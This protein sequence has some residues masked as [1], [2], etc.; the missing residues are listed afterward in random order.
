MQEITFITSHPKKAAQISWHLG[1][2]VTHHKLD[3]LEIQSLDPHEVAR[4]KAEESVSPVKTS[5]T[6]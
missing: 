6:G 4:I 1:Y 3:L 5:C 2:P